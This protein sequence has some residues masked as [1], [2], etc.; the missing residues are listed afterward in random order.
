MCILL[1]LLNIS[2]VHVFVHQFPALKARDIP[3]RAEGPGKQNPHT[4]QSP[5]V[6]EILIRQ[7]SK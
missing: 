5:E 6:G 1:L 3:A 4:I 2:V 7:Y